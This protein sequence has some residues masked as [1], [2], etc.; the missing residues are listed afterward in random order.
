MEELEEL[1]GEPHRAFLE[2]HL[3]YQM[4]LLKLMQK[5]LLKVLVLGELKKENLQ[6]SS[7]KLD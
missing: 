4:N 3:P 5:H 1:L 6:Q 7:Y 2:V